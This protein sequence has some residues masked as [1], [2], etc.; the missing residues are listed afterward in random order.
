MSFR[1]MEKP[2]A[3]VEFQEAVVTYEAQCSGRGV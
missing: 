2:E 1:L 3:R